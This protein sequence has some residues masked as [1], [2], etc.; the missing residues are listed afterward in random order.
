MLLT[1]EL[2]VADYAARYRDTATFGAACRACPGYGARW[3]C[4]PFPAGLETE[5]LRYRTALIVGFSFATADPDV[6]DAAAGE[7]RRHTAILLDIEQACGGRAFGFTGM[8]RLCAACTR[9]GGAPCRFPAMV[10]PALEAFGFD[11]GR[12][13][14]ELLG[15]PLQW[16][17][18]A[19][20]VRSLTFIGAVFH[21]LPSAMNHVAAL[22]VF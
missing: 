22:S 11:L 7:L 13:A 18:G 16:G 1:A 12:T 10:R 6:M 17:T 19:R 15:A 4:P 8:C 20:G 5:I 2:P 14:S 3:C 9:P 21:N